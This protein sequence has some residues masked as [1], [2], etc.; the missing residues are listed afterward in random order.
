[1][2]APNIKTFNLVYYSG[3][4]KIETVLTNVNKALCTWKQNQLK[5]TTHKIG[6]FKIE[7]NER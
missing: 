3:D 1:M 4:K 2:K 7:P 6:T 5:Q